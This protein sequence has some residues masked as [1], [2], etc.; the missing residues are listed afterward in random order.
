MRSGTLR[1]ESLKS[2]PQDLS[3]GRTAGGRYLGNNVVSLAHM[4]NDVEGM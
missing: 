4:I 3:T 1:G 2:K